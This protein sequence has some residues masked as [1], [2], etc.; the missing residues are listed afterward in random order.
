MNNI[1]FDD[2]GRGYVCIEC[3]EDLGL[4][5][6]PEAENEDAE[7]VICT[8]AERLVAGWP[9][10]GNNHDTTAIAARLHRSR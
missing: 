4:E 9:K 7:C 3:A 1:L 10:K 6:L 5:G 8:G 2:A